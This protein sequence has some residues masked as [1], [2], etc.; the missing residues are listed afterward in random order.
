MIWQVL[1]VN[2]WNNEKLDNLAETCKNMEALKNK[3][4]KVHKTMDKHKEEVS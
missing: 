3:E 1:Q 4:S 2:K